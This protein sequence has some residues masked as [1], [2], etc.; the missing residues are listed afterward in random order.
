MSDRIERA[1]G[2]HNKSKCGLA[3]VRQSRPTAIRERPAM[4]QFG[5]TADFALSPQDGD[6]LTRPGHSLRPFGLRKAGKCS[7]RL[8][9]TSNAGLAVRCSLQPS[10]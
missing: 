2:A 6:L 8:V 4:S 10:R 3:T 7:A 9:I 1:W 5:Q